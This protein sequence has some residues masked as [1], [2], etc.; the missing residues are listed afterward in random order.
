VREG[1]L[2]YLRD[3]V[4]SEQDGRH[5]RRHQ[6]ALAQ[7]GDGDERE[8]SERERPR[9]GQLR[10]AVDRRLQRWLR[11]DREGV[12]RRRVHPLAGGGEGRQPHGERADRAGEDQCEQHERAARHASGMARHTQRC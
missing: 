9:P 3:E 6:P 5:D 12:Q 7:Q 8:R 2:E 4:G 11:G 1:R 10:D